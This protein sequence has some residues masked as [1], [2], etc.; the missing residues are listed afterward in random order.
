MTKDAQVVGNFF[1][2]GYEWISGGP[3]ENHRELHTSD[4]ILYHLQL[5]VKVGR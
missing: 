2:E 4:S 5:C 3:E 1:E